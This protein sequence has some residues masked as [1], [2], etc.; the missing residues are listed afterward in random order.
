MV[1]RGGLWDKKELQRPRCL[2][3]NYD[4]GKFGNDLVVYK[5]CAANSGAKIDRNKPY[6][7]LWMGTHE[8]ERSYV[9][10]KGKVLENQKVG[11][12]SCMT[13]KSWIFF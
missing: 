10:I 13:L 4:Q 11:Y 7:E 2:V 6:A 8:F 1:N 9:I 3:K 12:S 5:L